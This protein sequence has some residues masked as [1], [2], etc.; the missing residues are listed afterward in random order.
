RLRMKK[1]GQ[2]LV[3]DNGGHILDVA[4]LKIVRPAELEAEINN[5]PGVITVG[6]FARKGADVCLLGT[7]DGVRTLK[8]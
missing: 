3:T 4:G 5:L 2:P 6:L 1:G 7:A 8:F